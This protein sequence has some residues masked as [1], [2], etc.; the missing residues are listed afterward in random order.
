MQA[1]VAACWVAKEVSSTALPARDEL[2]QSRFLKYHLLFFSA[3]TLC[4]LTTPLSERWAQCPGTLIH[5][6]G[7]KCDLCLVAVC[8]TEWPAVN[9]QDSVVMSLCGVK[10]LYSSLDIC[11]VQTCTYTQLMHLLSVSQI[12]QS[13]GLSWAGCSKGNR[14]PKRYWLWGYHGNSLPRGVGCL[15]KCALGGSYIQRHAC[16]CPPK[17]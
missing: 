10:R 6:A 4:S 8:D 17:Y 7:N 5:L 16:G 9:L 3:S 12:S 11:Q 13:V 2:A 14:G 15:L 1:H